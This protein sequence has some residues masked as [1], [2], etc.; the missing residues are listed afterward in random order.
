MRYIKLYE[1]FKEITSLEYMETDIPE[2]LNKRETDLLSKYSNDNLWDYID[3]SSD[4]SVKLEFYKKD[5]DY[6]YSILIEKQYD[7]YYL[8]SIEFQCSDDPE[9]DDSRYFILDTYEELEE[10]LQ[11]VEKFYNHKRR[12]NIDKISL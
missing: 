10:F 3:M 7:E 1:S 11:K 8:A 6:Y 2:S 5:S 4:S 9:K 12:F